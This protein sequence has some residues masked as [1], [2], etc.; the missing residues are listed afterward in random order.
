MKKSNKIRIL[1][2]S[3][4]L[5]CV[6]VVAVLSLRKPA[7]N[8]DG[9]A[10]DTRLLTDSISCIVAEYP[11]EIGVAVI[12]DNADTVTVNNRSVYPMMSVFKVHQALAV[13]ND[14]DR[15]GIALDTLVTIRRDEL[16]P[17]TWSPML[18]TP[19]GGVLFD[20][21]GTAAIYPDA[22]RQQCE[23]PYVQKVGWGFRDGQ[24]YC[25]HHSPHEFPDSLHGRGDV[26]RPQQGVL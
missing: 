7:R 12:I 17:E 11:G 13:C 3:V 26:G 24:S 9:A 20:A 8:N 1:V 25:H 19:G 16:D 14:F 21:R 4:S 22:K 18:R 6:V 15:K 10:L 23:Q 5:V 2:L